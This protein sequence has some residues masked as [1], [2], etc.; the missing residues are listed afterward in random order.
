MKLPETAYHAL[1]DDVINDV[2]DYVL[3]FDHLPFQ[4][5]NQV[6]YAR[7]LEDGSL[8]NSMRIKHEEWTGEIS[9]LKEFIHAQKVCTS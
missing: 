9:K 5:L 7:S 4:E 8:E 2:T 6:K 3:R 1:I